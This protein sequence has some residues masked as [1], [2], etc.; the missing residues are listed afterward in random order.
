MNLLQTDTHIDFM[1]GGRL[2]GRYE[3][4]DP[5]KP[6]LHPLHTPDGHCVTVA[7]PHDH[8]H[9]KGVMYALRTAAV[10]FWEEAPTR[11]GELVGVE[12]HL[13][14]PRLVADGDE[15][16]FEEDLLWAA[17]DGT[18]E[19]FRE[20]RS[21]FCRLE[22]DRQ[23]Y[24]WRWENRLVAASDLTL[25]QSP[26]S[27]QL[28]DGRLIN[29]DGLGVRMRREFGATRGS[30]LLIDGEQL[31]VADGMGRRPAAVTF[32]GSLDGY[33]PVRRAAI[34]VTQ[35]HAPHALFPLED[36]FAFISVGPSNDA[37][38]KL[39]RGQVLAERYEILVRDV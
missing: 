13:G 8:K 16:G 27:R 9:H 15:V 39:S 34:Q 14:F 28:A 4:A 6:Y 25:M 30:H 19:T 26:W 1:A 35:H 36:P 5:F 12:R 37:P 11:L 2:A 17:Q 24:R 21:I 38:V 3:L 29:Y 32:V 22:P 20:R 18:N 7:M 33:F 31:K 23:G 10:N